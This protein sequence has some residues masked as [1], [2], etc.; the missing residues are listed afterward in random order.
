[1]KIKQE[2]TTKLTMCYLVSY[3]EAEKGVNDFFSKT[4]RV[5]IKLTFGTGLALYCN[6][7]EFF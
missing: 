4:L 2:K 6:C 5:K 1:M 3:P 7:L